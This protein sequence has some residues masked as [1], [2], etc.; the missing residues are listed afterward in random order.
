VLG[1]QGVGWAVLLL[2]GALV[3]AAFGGM[4]ERVA[5]VVTVAAV[6]GTGFVTSRISWTI[7]KPAEITVALA[8]GAVKQT[9]KW[10]PAEL[11]GIMAL[12]RDLTVEALGADLIVWPE[13]A[14]PD[15]YEFQG[16]F[17][18]EIG[19]LASDAGSEVMLGLLR[20]QNG[21]AQNA[22]YTLGQEE[23]PYIK[24]HLVPYGEYFPVPDFVR[25]WMEALDL[26][27]IDTRPGDA[28]QPPIELLGERIAATIC[29]E[30]VFGAE[31]LHSFPEA[32]LLVNV[33]NDAWFGDSIAPHQHLQIARMR[34]AEVRRWQ[35]RATNTGITAVI[36]PYGE[37]VAQLPQFEPGVL[38]ATARGMDGATPYVRW[39]DWAVVALAVAVCGLGIAFRR[40]SRG[41]G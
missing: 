38:R 2:A 30:D 9:L 14:I 29:Y 12:Y 31:Q 4:R 22:L 23:S 32:T 7:E 18:D 17:L 25:D 16:R 20:W 21:A 35:L 13:A 41:A 26:P 15:Y 3:A 1:V 40:R 24:R 8:Q 39:G 5:A 28:G 19:Q 6:F 10:D 36:D 34:A 11:P 33:S 37:V 27:T